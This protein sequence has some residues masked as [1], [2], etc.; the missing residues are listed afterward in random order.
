M[1]PPRKPAAQHNRNGANVH[2][3]AAFWPR[4]PVRTA[5]IQ[6][7]LSALPKHRTDSLRL[8]GATIS[9]TR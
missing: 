6:R 8:T 7:S 2:T 4:D 3:Q 5:S 9:T 1:K